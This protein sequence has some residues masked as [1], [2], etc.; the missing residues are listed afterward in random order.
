MQAKEQQY[1]TPEEYLELETAAEYRSEYIDGQIIP[2]AGGLPNHNRIA[3]N[4][5]AGL[6]YAFRGK[7][8]YAFINDLRVWIPDYRVY[9][10]PDVMIIANNLEYAQ[11]RRDTVVNPVAIAEVLSDSTEKYDRGE[12]F[13]M[14]RTIPTLKEYILIN[15]KEMH[16]EQFVQNQQGQWLFNDY[17][18][19]A[20]V[21]KLTSVEF[22]IPLLELYDKVNFETPE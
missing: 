10:Y 5:Y 19:E 13:R 22:S 18:G 3:G 15:Q 11:G 8:Y 7:P 17:E 1:Y 16:L 6:N 2:M 9:T 20:T 21:L 12:K 14:Y 4:L